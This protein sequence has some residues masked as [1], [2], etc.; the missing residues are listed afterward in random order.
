[1]YFSTPK[2]TLLSF[3]YFISWRVLK[4]EVQGKKVSRPIVRL[5]IISI[6]LAVVVNLI[7]IAVVTGFQHKVTEKVTGFGSHIFIMSAGDNSIYESQPILKNQTFFPELAKEE[8]IKSIQYVAY[9][10]VLFQS[11]KKER[12]YKLKSGKDTTY[13]QQ[14]IQG[15]ILKGVDESYDLS[16]FKKHLIKGRLPKFYKDSISYE[17]LVSKRIAQDLNLELNDDL[18]AFF[19]KSQPIKRIFKLVGIYETGLEEIDKKMSIGDIRIVQDLND[20]GLKAAIEV[21]D[22]LTNGQLIVKAVVS[23]GKSEGDY[24]YDWGEGFD[25]YS[26]FTICPTKDT[27]VRLIVADYSTNLRSK[28]EPQTIPDTAYLKIKIKGNAFSP[29]DFKLDDE[30]KLIRTFHSDDGMN[31]SITASG[32]EVY[33]EK[34]DGKGSS[35]NYVGGFEISVDDW[36]QLPLIVE[37]LKKRF[38]LIPTE[39]NEILSVR[40]I[41]ETQSDI[42][43]WLGFLDLNVII[44]LTLMIPIGIINMGSALL[45]L[46]LVRTNFIG[47]MKAMGASNW[48]IRKIF[49]IQAGFLI[50]RGML[51]GNIVGLAF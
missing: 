13:I 14:E 26:G 33:F 5:S 38:E 16:F 11:D 2:Y 9:K 17:I 15:A 32:K 8:G 44:I 29:C 18:R 42:F 1:M 28:E 22:T 45:V 25:S 48:S 31:Y 19:V 20:W 49:L 3:E 46:I 10:P 12:H 50:L 36:N 41:N 21:D 39:N 30:H 34:K 24:L 6:S 47:M 51:F 37:R 35:Q 23:G 40:G 4:S 7:T 27:T 43:V